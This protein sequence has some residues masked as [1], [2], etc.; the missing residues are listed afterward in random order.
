[1]L[2]FSAFSQ[3]IMHFGESIHEATEAPMTGT[4]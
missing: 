1:M 4:V 2:N 3:A